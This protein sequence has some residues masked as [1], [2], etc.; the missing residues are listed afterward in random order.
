VGAGCGSISIEWLRAGRQMRA[1]AIESDTER[2][3]FIAAN[4]AALGTPDIEVVAGKAPAALEGLAPP[5]A[6][7]IGGGIT[8][9]GLVERCWAALPSGG[10]LV[11]NAVTVQGESRLLQCRDEMGG[12][13]GRIAISRAEPIGPYLGWRPLMPV[14]QWAAVK[15]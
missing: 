1:L 12:S 13:L 4:A 2:R 14:T 15:S 7:F 9:P 3:G 6:V 8:A 11:A 10:R 5:D